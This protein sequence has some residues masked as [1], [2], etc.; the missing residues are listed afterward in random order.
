MLVEVCRA[1]SVPKATILS[2]V[3]AL[4]H[5]AGPH[6]R[7]AMIQTS[8]YESPTCHL[9]ALC[10]AAARAM[11]D[12][13]HYLLDQGADDTVLCSGR[14]ACQTTRQ[15]PIPPSAIRTARPTFYCSTVNGHNVTAL[16]FARLMYA[17]EIESGATVQNLQDLFRCVQLLQYKKNND[18]NDGK[19]ILKL[20]TTKE[21][22]EDQVDQEPTGVDSHMLTHDMLLHLYSGLRGCPYLLPL[23]PLHFISTV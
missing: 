23:N 8:T 22:Q 17:A 1:K 4:V 14:F 19:S 11:P 16:D 10:V 5:H 2:C 9:T 12:V 21:G 6:G 7:H 3:K 18:N 15:R 20:I 13:V